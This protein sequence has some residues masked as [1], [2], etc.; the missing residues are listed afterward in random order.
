MPLIVRFPKKYQHLAPAQPGSAIEELVTLMDLGPSVLGLANLETPDWMQGRPLLCKTSEGEIQYHEYVIGMRDRLD[1]RYEMVR[2]VR[3][4]RFRYQRNYYPHLPFKPHEDFEFNA[5]VLKKWVELARAG[6]LTG[7]QL[8]LN[9][10]FKPMEELY[11]SQN[12]PL[13]I[14]NVIDDP[15]YAEVVKRMRGQ[16]RE[17]MIETR[18][19][20]MLDEAETLQRAE[21]HESH[22]HLGQSLDN[23]ERILDTADLLALGKAGASELL[24]RVHDPDSA[25]RF[26][27]VLGLLALRSNDAEV[28]SAL[29][30]ATK[31]ASVSVRI[32][33][34][35]GLFN[36]GRYEDGLP[37]LVDALSHPVP[38]ARIRASCVLDMQPPAANEKLGPAVEAL[39]AAASDLDV[40]KMK[41]IP[42]GLNTPFER[43]IKAITGEE[44]YYRWGPVVSE[45]Q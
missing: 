32:T 9:L 3:D 17:W 35:D 2:T 23:Y 18:D 5:P 21:S 13:L 16:L 38:A 12:D 1:S 37:V 14:R 27:A 44:T 33:A 40:K 42:Y 20:G 28:V 10:R 29:Q 22:W 6:K 36:L 25:V 11:D 15:Q 43:A 41:G 39:R 4:E 30:A 34:A 45:S 7:P 8:Q 31:D 26:W 24:T 19:L